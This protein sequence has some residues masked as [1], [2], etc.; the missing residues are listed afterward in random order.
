MGKFRDLTGMKFSR[1]TVIGQSGRS[2]DGHIKWLCQCD[3]GKGII[4]LGGPLVSGNTNSCGCLQK[5]RASE[6]SI[7]DLTGMQFGRLTVIG[8]AGRT[9]CNHVKWKCLCEC[10]N[11]TTVSGGSLNRGLTISCGCYNKERTTETHR[12][13]LTGKVFGRLTV[14]EEVGRR[15]GRVLWKCQCSCG[16]ISMVVGKSLLI[17]DTNSC[18]CLQKENVSGENNVNW[19]GGIS[20]LTA[21]IR[22][23]SEYVI[24]RKQVFRKD[25]FTCI[26]CNDSTGGNLIAHHI[27]FFSAILD[28]YNITTLEEAIQ[29]DVLWDTNNG[30][31]LCVECHEREHTRLKVLTSQVGLSIFNP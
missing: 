16:N 30:I 28:E 22:G 21:Q 11:E 14:L 2:N 9:K 27:K 29:C 17:G 1:L 10:G 5:E 12:I 13:D 3:C 6:S 18:G 26:H 25:N 19:K 7:K 31:T 4:V 15:D 24:W 20:T 8:Q 23:C